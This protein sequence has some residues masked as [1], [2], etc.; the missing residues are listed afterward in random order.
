MSDGKVSFQGVIVSVQPRIRL[1]R[2]FDER[3]HNYLVMH[4]S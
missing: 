3:F 1:I 2:S 4:W